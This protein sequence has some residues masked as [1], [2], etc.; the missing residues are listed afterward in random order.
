ME[1]LIESI[2]WVPLLH[3]FFLCLSPNILQITFSVHAQVVTGLRSF[4]PLTFAVG[5]V[6]KQE[7]FS[8]G[9]GGVQTGFLGLGVHLVTNRLVIVRCGLLDRET[10]KLITKHRILVLFHLRQL[11]THTVYFKK[12]CCSCQLLYVF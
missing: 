10:V 8:Q 9:I 3:R 6:G 12:N 1:F 7:S 4:T 5:F 11:T 2:N